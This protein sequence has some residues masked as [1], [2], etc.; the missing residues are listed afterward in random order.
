M[1]Y[2]LKNTLIPCCH[3]QGAEALQLYLELEGNPA[4]K[5]SED[6]E[7]QIN[8]QRFAADWTV[9]VLGRVY[10]SHSGVRQGPHPTRSLRSLRYHGPCR[11]CGPTTAHPRPHPAALLPPLLPLQAA[12]WAH[13]SH[14]LLQRPFSPGAVLTALQLTN[15][16]RHA[17]RWGRGATGNEG[18]GTKHSPLTWKFGLRDEGGGEADADTQGAPGH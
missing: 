2:K 4:T 17:F 12:R 11:P 1:L 16:E 18:E 14:E 9:W 6:N 3:A 8:M 15:E 7:S 5:V 13:V 10:L